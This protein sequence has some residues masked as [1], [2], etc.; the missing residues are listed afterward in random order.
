MT[1]PNDETGSILQEMQDAGIDL[2]IEWPVEFFQL[3]EQEKDARAMAEFLA[4]EMPNATVK[5]HPD[6]TP[7]VWDVDVTITMTP[8]HQ[9]I[10]E[11]EIA[12]EK[13]S[14]KFNGYNDGWGIQ[15][16]E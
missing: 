9:N 16:P 4:A 10:S 15:V 13:L 12:F 7:S 6:A 5:V 2:S 11:Q 1:F 8:S 14:A 3:F